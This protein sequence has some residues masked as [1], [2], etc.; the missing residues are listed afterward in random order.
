MDGSESYKVNNNILHVV[1][2]LSCKSLWELPQN[3]DI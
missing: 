3:T 1:N 2:H